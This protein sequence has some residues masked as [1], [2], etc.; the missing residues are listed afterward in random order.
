MRY[1]N[2]QDSSGYTHPAYQCRHRSLGYPHYIY[3]THHT[4]RVLGTDSPYT[5]MSC[6]RNGVCAI[7]LRLYSSTECLKRVHTSPGPLLEICISHKLWFQ[8]LSTTFMYTVPIHNS[9][10]F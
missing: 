9:P 2:R 10:K 6:S 7:L 4:S 1:N 5:C 3:S 8:S